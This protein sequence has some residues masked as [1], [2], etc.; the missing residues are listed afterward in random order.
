MAI[1]PLRT[2]RGNVYAEGEIVGPFVVVNLSQYMPNKT[3]YFG[4]SHVKTGWGF[5][6]FSDKDVAAAF[7]SHI[8]ELLDWDTI[9]AAV[10]AGIS[11]EDMPERDELIRLYRRSFHETHSLLPL[12]VADYMSLVI[13]QE[14]LEHLESMDGSGN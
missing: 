12:H 2:M 8:A 4:I 6:A 7:A 3:I 10:E 14:V 9:Y 5:A 1:V 13:I 11:M